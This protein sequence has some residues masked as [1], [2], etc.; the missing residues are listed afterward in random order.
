MI[1]AFL[2]WLAR[3]GHG[4]MKIVTCLCGNQRAEDGFCLF[5]TILIDRN[6]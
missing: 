6:S 3:N 2:Q 5:Q 1:A 4:A